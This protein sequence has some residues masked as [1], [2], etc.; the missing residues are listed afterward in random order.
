MPNSM[1]LNEITQRW[2]DSTN[3]SGQALGVTGR[4]A[5]TY[6]N[7]FV[8]Q[9]QNMCDGSAVKEDQTIQIQLP[10]PSE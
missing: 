1:D 3:M 8:A 2:K 10:T 9:P 5:Y 7:I 4:V 6:R